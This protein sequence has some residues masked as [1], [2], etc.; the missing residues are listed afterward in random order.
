MQET[1]SWLVEQ[2]LDPSASNVCSMQPIHAAVKQQLPDAIDALCLLGI[3]AN[4]Q[5]STEDA[6]SPLQMHLN[7]CILQLGV[8]PQVEILKTLIRHGADLALKNGRGFTALSILFWLMEASRQESNARQALL[9]PGFE[10][11][12]VSS[13]RCFPIHAAFVP[14]VRAQAQAQALAQGHEPVDPANV[15]VCGDDDSDDADQGDCESESSAS[16]ADASDRSSAASA[17]ARTAASSDSS[18][19]S[20]SSRNTVNN[21]RIP[22]YLQ[23]DRPQRA[24]IEAVVQKFGLEL[25]SMGAAVLVGPMHWPSVDRSLRLAGIRLRHVPALKVMC[26]RTVRASVG[27]VQFQHKVDLLPLPGSLKAYLKEL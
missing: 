16:T 8:E 20:R 21:T 1:L 24:F 25:F 19:H 3:D 17:S 13:M 12:P 27:G 2:G 5:I 22:M 10:L 23:P 15:A 18:T 4:A 11:A 14:V 7:L 9:S 26:W 6:L